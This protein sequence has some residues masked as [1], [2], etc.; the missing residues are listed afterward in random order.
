MRTGE[1]NVLPTRLGKRFS[2]TR[3]GG[4]GETMSIIET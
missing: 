2:S 1:G 3:A 4:A